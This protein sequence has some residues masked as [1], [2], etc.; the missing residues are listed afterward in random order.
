MEK[1]TLLQNGVRLFWTI[2]IHW[3]DLGTRIWLP[4]NFAGVNEIIT[5]WTW[6]FV[7]CQKE[8]SQDWDWFDTLQWYK[9]IQQLL[10]SGDVCLGCSGASLL[11][12][13]APKPTEPGTHYTDLS[14]CKIKKL[15]KARWL[16]QN[17]HIDPIRCMQGCTTKINH[18]QTTQDGI[19]YTLSMT[20]IFSW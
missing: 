1:I 20:W 19:H 10:L 16:P 9:Y 4:M 12:Q 17:E 7:T 18:W 11:A 14:G 2:I 8:T 15:Y 13:Q 5:E 3:K 6:L